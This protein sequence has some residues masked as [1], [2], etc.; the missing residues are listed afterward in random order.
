M[1]VCDLFAQLG[2]RGVSVLV[3]TGDNGVGQ[4]NCK[5]ND[6]SVRFIPSYPATCMCG[7]FLPL[8]VVHSAGPGRSPRRHALAGPW[9]TA[10]G[11]MTGYDPEVAASFSGGGFSATLSARATRIMPCPPSSRIS[12]AGIRCSLT[13]YALAHD[14]PHQPIPFPIPGVG[15]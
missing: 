7:V 9:V 4:G 10:V 8:G 6:G 3:A 15:R 11:G 5:T 12:A 14:A 2:A 1:C 13:R